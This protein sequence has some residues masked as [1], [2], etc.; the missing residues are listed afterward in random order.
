[1]FV[2]IARNTFLA[3]IYPFFSS[4]IDAGDENRVVGSGVDKQ[5]TE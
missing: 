4:V 1:M 2:T 5:S 3:N